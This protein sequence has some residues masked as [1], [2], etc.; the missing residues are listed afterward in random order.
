[1]LCPSARRT[2]INK[3]GCRREK[4]CAPVVFTSVDL[5]MDET[6]LRSEC[7]KPRPIV[8]ARQKGNGKRQ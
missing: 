3:L 4:S 7:A 8:F 5:V 6:N 1:M 2:F